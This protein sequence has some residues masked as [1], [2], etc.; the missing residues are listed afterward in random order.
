MI[1]VEGDIVFNLAHGY[2]DSNTYNKIII[3][4]DNVTI[5]LTI[6]DIYQYINGE[7]DGSIMYKAYGYKNGV[8]TRIN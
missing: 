2:N 8:W 4:Y 3:S 6:M 7:W 1:P 5:T